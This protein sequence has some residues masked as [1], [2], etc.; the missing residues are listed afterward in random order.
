MQ[1][2]EPVVKRINN[3]SM[4]PNEILALGAEFVITTYS[5]LA[6]CFKTWQREHT[7]H[8][9]A[10]NVG[11]PAAKQ[12][13]IKEE[14]GSETA[15]VYG[16]LSPM[17]EGKGLFVRHLILDEV[18]IISKRQTL[19]HQAV[20]KIKYNRV[21]ML[22]GTV[23][24]HN[25]PQVSGLLELF[26]VEHPFDTAPRFE[27]AFTETWLQRSP[28]P[29]VSKFDRFVK[30][31]MAVTVARPASVLK[32]PALQVETLRFEL[33]EEA[34]RNCT[35]WAYRLVLAL[36]AK[37]GVLDNDDVAGAV[38]GGGHIF[39]FATF[40]QQWAA[41]ELLA[42]T[43]KDDEGLQLTDN[44][45]DDML[46]K[47]R[48]MIIKKQQAPDTESQVSDREAYTELANQFVEEK[49]LDTFEV[50]NI[51]PTVKALTDDGGDISS[52]GSNESTSE[53][54]PHPSPT[55]VDGDAVQEEHLQS[56]I[57]QGLPSAEPDEPSHTE[58][59]DES[60][61]QTRTEWLDIVS[62][63][64]AFSLATPRINC[65][66]DAIK[67]ITRH[68]PG[69]KILVFSVYLRFLDLLSQAIRRDYHLGSTYI[70]Q[71]NG[72]ITPTKRAQA[73]AN[74]SMLSEDQCGIFLITSN[75]GGASI[76]LQVANH[77]IL[78]EPWWSRNDV[79]QAIARCYR[80]GQ[81]RNAYVWKIIGTNSLID[82]VLLATQERKAS[83]NAKFMKL[84]RR[85]DDEL[86][87]I[88]LVTAGRA[89]ES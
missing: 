36:Q 60:S 8:E 75:A 81:A 15:Q 25:W 87:K 4:T 85:P 14:M 41:A 6:A 55:P 63:S 10:Q 39:S 33:D 40:A 26:P 56:F 23:I 68:E 67:S 7:F 78:S 80:Q 76:N 45:L 43:R 53:I 11:Y 12:S 17:F 79:S 29:P 37:G 20:M 13:A 48:M 64:S 27:K 73:V 62:K 51:L 84:L 59:P 49:R 44:W 47:A 18:H 35:Y 70:G 22:S 66:I 83:I 52:Q 74:F 16:I 50:R 1:G 82:S 72:M 58:E 88:P 77:V 86:P 38:G 57:D 69:A 65:I 89:G 32:L 71:F 31:F 28:P 5:N 2:R 9:Y 3:G 34:Q 19:A 61:H 54:P 30:F 21:L 24:P 46:D 42:P